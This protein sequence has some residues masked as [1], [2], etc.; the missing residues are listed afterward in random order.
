MDVFYTSVSLSG[1]TRCSRPISS[2]VSCLCPRISPSSKDPQF[3]LLQKLLE[4]DLWSR[5][6]YYKWGN[7]ASLIL[8]SK[9]KISDHVGRQCG[10]MAN[11]NLC[12]EC[13]PRHCP[14][15]KGLAG[16][17]KTCRTRKGCLVLFWP[18]PR[19]VPEW[20]VECRKAECLLS[21]PF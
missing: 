2:G 3:L 21:L 19:S 17:Q 16:S 7:K 8:Q 4:T 6:A 11:E 14:S 9:V 15:E 20:P 13:R 10:P 18:H 1:T 12:E 5:C